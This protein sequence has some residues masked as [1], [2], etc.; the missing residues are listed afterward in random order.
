VLPAFSV[1]AAAAERPAVAVPKAVVAALLLVD[2]LA[3]L[4][5]AYLAARLLELATAVEACS[6][7]PQAMEVASSGLRQLL[8]PARQRWLQRAR[9]LQEVLSR[10]EHKL[11]AR[12]CLV[13]PQAVVAVE[14]AFHSLARQPAAVAVQEVAFLC[15]VE[16][17]LAAGAVLG[18]EV[19]SRSSARLQALAVE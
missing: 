13:H 2:L 12:P 8:L 17:A 10:S 11:V 19:A 1:L 6:A 7:Q 14:V 5:V 4:A 15:L 3:R 16:P 18:A 9:R